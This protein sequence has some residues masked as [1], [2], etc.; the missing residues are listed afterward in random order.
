MNEEKD[1]KKF[2]KKYRLTFPVGKETGIAKA[3]GAGGIPETIFINK[4]GKIIKRHTDTID[5][6]QLKKGIEA[7]IRDENTI[8]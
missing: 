1:I 8:H 7:L 4:E 6:K 3:L 5:F 2:A